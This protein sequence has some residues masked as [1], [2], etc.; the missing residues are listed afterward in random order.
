MIQV[1]TIEQANE[2]R[3]VRSIQ[4]YMQGEN[5]CTLSW[6]RGVIDSDVQLA[7]QLLSARFSAYSHTPQFRKIDE[8]L[9][10]PTPNT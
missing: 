10:E 3:I 5:G 6:I 4:P 1:S 7:R 9:S 8:L 2:R